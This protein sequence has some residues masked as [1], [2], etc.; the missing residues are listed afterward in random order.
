M[1]FLRAAEFKKEEEEEEDDEEE[2]AKAE[3]GC[4]S[5]DCEAE[6]EDDRA[7]ADVDANRPLDAD[8][9]DAKA[10]WAW[11]G[12]ERRE[13]RRRVV[14]VVE[15][16]PYTAVTEDESVESGEGERE[17][18]RADA[19]LEAGGNGWPVMTAVFFLCFLSFKEVGGGVGGEADGG[20]TTWREEEEDEA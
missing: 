1:S 9:A 5:L 11:L 6:A 15:D 10:G 3:E 12:R 16:C 2:K 19:L 8:N 18:P 20:N 7:P 13:I 17:A 14:P 4:K